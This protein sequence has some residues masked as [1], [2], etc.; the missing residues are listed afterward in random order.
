MKVY[1]KIGIIAFLIFFTIISTCFAATLV[2]DA[3]SGTVD[4]YIVYYG[5]SWSNAS[6]VDVGNTTQFNIDRLPLTE[7][8]QYFAISAYN[9]AGESDPCDPIAYTP[10][11]TTPPQPP[12]GLVAQ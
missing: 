11:D 8:M 9:S 1:T 6:S 5:T 7:N 2:W 10:S 3:S 12:T 4:G